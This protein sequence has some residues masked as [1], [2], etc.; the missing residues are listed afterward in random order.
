MFLREKLNERIWIKQKIKELKKH[1][2]VQT[3]QQDDVLKKLLSLLDD[4]RTVNLVIHKINNDYTI[5]VAGTKISLNTA[6]ELRK[7]IKYK[8]SVISEIINLNS[9]KLDVL[10]LIDQRDELI[11]EYSVI[12][13]AVSQAD[14]KI[15]LE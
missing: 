1:A 14:W 6:I 15:K 9:D 4:L 12:D 5:E 10:S 13:N 3:K 2:L 7:T 11:D 8:I